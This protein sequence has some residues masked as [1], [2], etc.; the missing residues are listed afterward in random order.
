MSSDPNCMTIGN[1]PTPPPGY[2][3]VNG[4]VMG[5]PGMVNGQLTAGMIHPGMMGMPNGTPMGGNYYMN[6]QE[7]MNGSNEAVGM[8]MAG[9]NVVDGGYMMQNGNMAQ[10][11]PSGLMA[12]NGYSSSYGTQMGGMDQVSMGGPMTPGYNSNAPFS[13]GYFPAQQGSVKDDSS[14][15]ALCKY[16]LHGIC[17]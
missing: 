17:L 5:M 4:S 6:G 15:N 16:L 8:W 12:M 2:N 11:D 3:S 1:K 9:N 13:Y 10:L 14:Q 7:V